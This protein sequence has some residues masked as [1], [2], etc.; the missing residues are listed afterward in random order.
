M[1]DLNMCRYELQLPTYL[2]IISTSPIIYF[3]IQ[4]R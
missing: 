3:Q 2:R 4:S 1:L